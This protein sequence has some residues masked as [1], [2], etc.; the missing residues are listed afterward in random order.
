MP[1]RRNRYEIYAELL[2]TVARRRACKLTNASYGANLPVDR[3]KAMLTFLASR[4]FVSVNKVS[5]STMYTITKRGLEYL[6]TFRNMRKLFAALDE[7]HGLPAMKAPGETS[8]VSKVE[9]DLVFAEDHVPVD[10]EVRLGITV[11]NA[12]ETSVVLKS[13]ERVVPES[14]EVV[15]MPEH[16]SLKGDS[17]VAE[18]V[19]LDPGSKQEIRLGY[20]APREGTYRINPRIISS[21]DQGEEVISE[22]PPATVRV[23]EAGISRRLTTGYKELDSLLLGGIPERYAM[24]LTSSP[25]DE[26]DLLTLRFLKE[27]IRQ[28][29][30]TFY[31]ATDAN[32]VKT[33]SIEASPSF[34]VFVCNRQADV[35][36]GDRPNIIKLKGVDNLTDLNIALTSTVRKMNKRPEAQKRACIGILSDILLEHGA[37][38]TRKWL[39]GFLSELK[40]QG[41]TSIV[42]LNPQMHSPEEVQAVLDPFEGE[43]DIYARQTKEGA[44]RYL[45]IRRMFN[46]RYLENEMQLIKE[47]LRA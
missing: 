26:R 12:G 4:G 31:F 7:K 24:I 33:L 23:A 6:E 47:K 5:G 41:F 18:D 37:M 13:I 42:L 1:E 29:E 3:A 22:P 40:S 20:R 8:G 16:F 44:Q 11:A 14:F 9:A 35:I 17:I 27:G 2:D 32:I 19:V 34:Y 28:K 36:V 38:H 45:R 10:E 39:T 21:D 25:C 15:F 43:I 46:Q 30:T